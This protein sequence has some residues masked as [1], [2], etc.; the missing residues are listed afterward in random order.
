MRRYRRQK[1]SVKIIK[2]LLDNVIF[3]AKGVSSP[4]MIHFVFDRYVE[5]KIKDSERLKRKLHGTYELSD[6]Y[7]CAALPSM[8]DSFYGSDSNKRKLIYCA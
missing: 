8:M 3:N 1:L 6:I 7:P 2:D 4:R 5:S